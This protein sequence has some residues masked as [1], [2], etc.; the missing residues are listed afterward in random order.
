MSDSERKMGVSERHTPSKEYATQMDSQDPLGGMRARFYIPAG[1][2]G[3][4]AVYFTGNSLGL[5]PRSAR[6]YIEEALD[7]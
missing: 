4:E 1:A 6:A 5:Q 3:S 7:D 2:D